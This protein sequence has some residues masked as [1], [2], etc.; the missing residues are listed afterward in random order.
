MENKVFLTAEDFSSRRL[1]KGIF[2]NLQK[3]I[4][5]EEAAIKYPSSKFQP[6]TKGVLDNYIKSIYDNTGGEIVK[7]GFNDTPEV[8]EYLEEA[9]KQ[10]SILKGEM[11]EMPN[12]ELKEVFFLPI[13]ETFQK[14]KSEE[15]ENTLEKGA[16]RDS[17]FYGDSFLK[18][19][20][21]GSEIKEK[22][23]ALKSKIEAKVATLKSE[24]ADMQDKLNYQPKEKCYHDSSSACCEDYKVFP[25]EM[26]YCETKSGHIGSVKI[27][28][29][30]SGT[31]SKEDCDLHRKWN[32]AVYKYVNEQSEIEAIEMLIENLED[33]KNFELTGRQM[34]TF[35]F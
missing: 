29:Y 9:K 8:A 11:V 1:N 30:N 32:D 18:F 22:V 20:K 24:I 26:T 34:V 2:T 10:L 31:I 28:D 14:A 7:G 4:T 16:V 35:G 6:I 17:M 27:D 25:W 5:S 19:T 21:K 12:G 33:D 15:D 13:T 3:S 23:T